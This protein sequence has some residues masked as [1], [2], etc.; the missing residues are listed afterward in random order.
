MKNTATYLDT[1]QA[2]EA[3]QIISPRVSNKY[4]PIL[5]TDVIKA[6]SPEFNFVSGVKFVRGRSKHYVD[7]VNKAGDQIRVYNSFDR[8]LALRASLISDGL[9]IDLGVDRLVHI[10][11]RAKD[12]T[13]T[14]ENT[15]ADIIKNI[16]TTKKMVRKLSKEVITPEMAKD[17][18]DI[19]F[20]KV[21]KK[22]ATEYTNYTDV[23]MENK[24]ITITNY[25]KGTLT[26]YFSGN[27][28]Y[29]KKGEKRN[30]LKKDSMLAKVKI[31]NKLMAFLEEAY[32]E[33]FL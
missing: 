16:K 31:E 3:I 6:L 27:Y 29:V 1:I 25:V 26:N 10:G 17:I 22:G 20:A 4:V 9:V 7:L 21:M 15:K 19:V 23:L 30:G 32:L 11:Q 12:F 13:E 24:D 5:T 18:S 28:T 33:Y 8:S 14:L 2:V